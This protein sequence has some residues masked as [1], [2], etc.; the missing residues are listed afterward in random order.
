MVLTGLARLASVTGWALAFVLC[1]GTRLGSAHCSILASVALT[2]VPRCV[3]KKKTNKVNTTHHNINN[4]QQAH[5][6][7]CL[8]SHISYLVRIRTNFTVISGV[9]IWT[10][11]AVGGQ[12][13]WDTGSS[14]QTGLFTTGVGCRRINDNR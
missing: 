8:R 7:F 1:T 4:T 5:W 11:T 12:S 14:V 13:L 9:A 6:V 2:S 10:D 3:G